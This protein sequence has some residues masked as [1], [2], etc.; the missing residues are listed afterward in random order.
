M[1]RRFA[2]FVV[3]LSS[4]SILVIEIV[5]GRMLAPYVGVTLETF[6]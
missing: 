4:A 2:E 1:S 5:A 3:F 6:T